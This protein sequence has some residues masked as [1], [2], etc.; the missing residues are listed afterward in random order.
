MSQIGQI[1][2]FFF[3]C[4]VILHIPRCPLF[5]VKKKCDFFP[6]IRSRNDNYLIFLSD[7]DTKSVQT[8]NIFRID[9]IIR[10]R[11]Q[12][13]YTDTSDQWCLIANRKHIKSKKNTCKHTQVQCT[14]KM[15]E[16]VVDFQR[17]FPF[18]Q[19]PICKILIF[20]LC[21]S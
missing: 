6:E 17:N 16:N 18:C 4:S 3:D 12:I 21:Y 19:I 9:V 8:K 7:F 11:V 14:L 20:L 5:L 15:N 13:L 10:Y 2:P 1:S